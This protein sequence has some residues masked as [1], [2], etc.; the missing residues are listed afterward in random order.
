MNPRRARRTGALFAILGVLVG[1][2]MVAGAA[3][4]S[5]TLVALTLA[6]AVCGT[7]RPVPQPGELPLHASDPAGFTLHWRLDQTAGAVVADG[8]LE[9]TRLD[10][11]SLV[12]MELAGLDASGSVVS[13][14]RTTATPRDFTG[15]TPWPFTIRLRPAGG[16]ARFVVRVVDVLPKVTPG[17]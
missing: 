17:R 5:G 8:V 15:T 11:Y 1:D 2:G 10:R 12:T 3:G 14:G 9:A 16:E 7:L 13:R 6:L 4:V